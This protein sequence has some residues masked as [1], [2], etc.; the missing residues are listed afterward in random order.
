MAR[1][2]DMAVQDIIDLYQYSNEA[3][4]E[5]RTASMLC[6]NFVMNKQWT[7]AEIAAFLKIG[8]AHV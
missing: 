2:Y 1:K 7:D 4:G 8:R 6:Y 5:S 3:W